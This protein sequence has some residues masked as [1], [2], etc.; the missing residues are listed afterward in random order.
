[1]EVGPGGHFFGAQHTLGAL[2][3]SLLPAADLR[4]A[5][6]AA[7]GRKQDRRRRPESERAM[8]TGVRGVSG[9][10]DLDPG[11]SEEIDAF[12]SRRVAEGGQ[13]SDY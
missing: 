9:A 4:L 10:A 7:S 2:C 6:L 1:M 13:V 11:I 3:D 5:Q 12:V 8:E